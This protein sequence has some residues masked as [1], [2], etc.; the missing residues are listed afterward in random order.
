MI[1][2]TQLKSLSWPKRF[3]IIIC[4]LFF[5]AFV[6]NEFSEYYRMSK[7]WRW[8]YVYGQRISGFLILTTLI[9]SPINSLVISRNNREGWKLNALWVI[10]G[11]IPIIYL[12]VSILFW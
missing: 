4:F 9:A 7:E 10:I 1:L 8:V 12:M 6:L 11:L 2:I 5:T 3:V